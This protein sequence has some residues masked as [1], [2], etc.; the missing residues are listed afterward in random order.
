MF[1]AV[2]SEVSD[3]QLNNINNRLLTRLQEEFGVKKIPKD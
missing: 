2:Y 1:Q 3:Y